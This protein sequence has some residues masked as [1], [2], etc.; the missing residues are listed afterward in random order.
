MFCVLHL[1]Y[2]Q[3]VAQIFAVVGAEQSGNKFRYR[4]G[5][6]LTKYDHS[7]CP[8]I[9]FSVG[10]MCL[11]ERGQASTE[12]CKLDKLDVESTSLLRWITNDLACQKIASVSV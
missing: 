12:T 6:Y 10:F 5:M 3:S 9:N 1:F 2:P 8:L 7:R 11:K 4:S